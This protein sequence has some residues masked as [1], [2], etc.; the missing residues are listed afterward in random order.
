MQGG[1]VYFMITNFYTPPE[2]IQK[3]T[4]TIDGDEAKH[5]LSVM[6]YRCGDT[7]S[8]VDGK[9][10]RYNVLIEKT[11]KASLQG[12]IL[13]RIRKENEPDSHI[14]LAQAIGRQE[15]MDFLI[16]KAT[17]IGVSSIIPIQTERG[18]VKF[19][20][21]TKSRAKMERWRRIAIAGMK[22]S[23]RTILPE[24]ENITPFENLLTRIKS[25][26][27]TLIASL[28]KDSKSIRDCE[29]LKRKTRKILLIV[30]PEAGFSPAELSKVKLQGAIPITLG[31]RR[32]RAE[33]AGMLFLSL[34]LH[35][36]NELG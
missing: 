28:E 4:L 33:S 26:D 5:I 19:G 25:Y 6:R 34:I 21:S 31:A 17:E 27:L 30:G 3:E 16:E 11:A 32:L 10:V 7:I 13:S 15:R 29:E 22:Q 1:D 14:T 20:G 8:V 36:L 35:H 18:L 2:K 23:L 12:K 24:I 9:G